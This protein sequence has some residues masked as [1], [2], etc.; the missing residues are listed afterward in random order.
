M[1]VLAE[2]F[3]QYYKRKFDAGGALQQVEYRAANGSA[4]RMSSQNV[5]VYV[6]FDVFSLR[7]RQGTH[8]TVSHYR[9]CG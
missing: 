2:G 4:V 8:D 3:Q 6:A 9:M 5:T 1:N 7:L